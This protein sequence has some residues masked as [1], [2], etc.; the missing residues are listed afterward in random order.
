MSTRI[1]LYLSLAALALAGCAQKAADVTPATAP[2]TE[3]PATTE[4]DAAAPAPTDAAGLL[5]A[6]VAGDHRSAEHKARDQYRHP[7]ETLEFFGVKP[8]MTVVELWAGGGWYTEVLAPYLKDQG[9][10]VA[11]SYDP[12]GPEGEYM[13]KSGRK[14]KEFLASNA[15]VYGKVET[16]IVKPPETIKLGEESGYAD[17]V[18]TFRNTHGWVR[19]GYEGKIYEEAFRALKPGGV[20]GV[21]QHRDKPDAKDADVKKRAESGYVSESYI[22]A[23]VEKVGFKLEAKS[24]I[25]A[26]AKDTKDYKDGVWT[27][28]PGFA[29]KEQDKSKYEAIGESDRMTLKFV[30]PAT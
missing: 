29:L 12:N 1:P 25:N 24:E 21:V 16:I 26:N 13:T 10:L 6:A 15:D 8:D 23:A 27:L 18:L 20:F 9:R 14:W 19:N 11:T 7:V 17:V 5:R 28:P 22:I 30:K 4:T 2:Q 3:A